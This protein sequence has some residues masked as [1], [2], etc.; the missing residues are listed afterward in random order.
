MIVETADDGMAWLHV[1]LPAVEAHAIHDRIT[2]QGKI[3]ARHPEETRTLDQ[4]RADMFGDLL[5]D[6]TTTHLPPRPAAS[7]PP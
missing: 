6:G 4:L 3:I 7:A 2:G 1:F 5:I